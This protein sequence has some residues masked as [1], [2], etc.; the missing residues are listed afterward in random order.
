MA[1]LTR[2]N[3]ARDM[4]HMRHEMGRLMNDLLRGD[5]EGNGT[6]WTGA[7]MPAVDVYENDD[8]LVFKAE[9]PGFSKD[10]VHVELKD[11]VLTLKGERKR[12]LEV[13]EEHYHRMERSY[14]TFQRSFALP[15]GVDAEKAEASFKDGVLKLTLP[16]A[17]T[18][19]PK[20]IGIN[21]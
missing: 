14:G 4:L 12:N 17:E 19:K 5:S 13:K 11:N 21:D 6:G 9:L 18:T 1:T 7:T 10:D 15:I 20:R 3:P 2:W 16:K 8:A